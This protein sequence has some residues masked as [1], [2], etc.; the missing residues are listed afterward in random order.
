RGTGLAPRSGMS[1]RLVHEQSAVEYFRELV[2]S[3]LDRQRVNARDIT[4]FYLV[5]LLAG[6]IHYDRSTLRGSEDAL[7]VRFLRALQDAGRRQHEALRQV[8]DLS[9]FISGFCSDS[10][11]RRL[12]DIDY[13]RQLGEYAYAALARRGDVALGDAFDELAE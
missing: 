4:S 12:V 6:F 5:N 2:E 9:L 1:A 13:Y 3:A 10:L 8:G 7:G 11:N